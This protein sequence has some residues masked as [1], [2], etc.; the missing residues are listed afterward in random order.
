M[1]V[2]VDEIHL[3]S[4]NEL[5]IIDIT[6]ILGDTLAK[7][8]LKNG[9]LTVFVP[10]S[11]GAVTTIEY[12]PGLLK[13]LP[14]ALER[15]FP[16]DLYY[17]HHETWHDDNGHSHVRASMMSPSLTIPFTGGRLILGTWQQVAFI[18]L[19]TRSRSRRLSVTIIG[20]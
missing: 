10:G 20:E 14:A 18:E 9:T 1:T 4:R 7:T 16:K 8:E 3:E 11:T 15:L 5:D 12:E 13:D 19:D 17:F 6:S 2:V